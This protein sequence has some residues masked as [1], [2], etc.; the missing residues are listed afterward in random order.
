MKP[1]RRGAEGWCDDCTRAYIHDQNLR[2]RYGITAAD[3]DRMYA[4]QG[5]ECLA[6]GDAEADGY[7]SGSRL[8][9]D[10]CHETGTVRGLLCQRCNLLIGHADECVERLRSAVEYL[11][12]A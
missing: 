2:K 8:H 4:Q 3:Y 11:E 12:A 1:P 9:V 7:G 6:C 10:H 5:G